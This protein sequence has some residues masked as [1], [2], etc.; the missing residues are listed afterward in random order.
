MVEN[1]ESTATTDNH[2][3]VDRMDGR[4]RAAGA[5][6]KPLSKPMP[7]VDAQ[8]LHRFPM[9]STSNLEELRQLGSALLGTSRIDLKSAGSFSARL[10][11][12]RLS[13]TALAFGTTSCYLDVDHA[14][15]DFI[16][17]QIAVKGS[18]TT[19]VGGRPTDI[20]LRQLA[21]TP[22]EVASRTTCEAGHE[23]FTLRL[24][25]QSLTQ[26]LTA[27]LGVRPKNE[28][29]FES[30]I[31]AAE[32]YTQG[33]LRLVFFLAEQLDSATPV[34]PVAAQVELEQA[35]QIAFLWASR[36]NLS[37]ALQ[38]EQAR[39]APAIVNRLEEY[40][41][42]HWRE[43]ITVERLVAEAGVSARS[44]FRAFELSRGYSPMAFAKAVRL[45]RARDILM[46]GDPHVSVTAT[47]FSCN[48]ASPGHFARDYRNAYGELPSQTIS[49]S[50]R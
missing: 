14:A 15:A 19:L 12:V 7:D 28:P 23:R 20:N 5:L 16:R 37:P 45:R 11:L 43:A 40:I 35:I 34:L 27:L 32:P 4:D 3:P 18:G 44:I 38:R 26:K 17:L 22:A 41:E 31:A 2:A 24:T 50:R 25:R 1:A 8:P 46:S 36:H 39:P 42:A 47:A 48:F 10:N 30:A 29:E 6:A 13:E 49:R 9:F 33:L 21:V